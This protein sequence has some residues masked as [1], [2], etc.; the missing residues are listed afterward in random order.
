MRFKKI[1]NNSYLKWVETNRLELRIMYLGSGESSRPSGPA[2]LKKILEKKEIIL[3]KWRHGTI[4][5]HFLIC[6]QT[7]SFYSISSCVFC[8]I[9]SRMFPFL[10][11]QL[12]EDR[13]CC[14]ARL[15]LLCNQ[16]ARWQHQQRYINLYRFQNSEC[17]IFIFREIKSTSPS[18]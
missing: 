18:V 13:L 3:N 16:V 10:N 2:R 6:T 15:N 9:K 8:S 7:I 4:F 17:T 11:L 5:S 14:R 1:E 12:R